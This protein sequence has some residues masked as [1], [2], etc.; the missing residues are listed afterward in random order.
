MTRPPRNVSSLET[1]GAI[2]AGVAKLKSAFSKGAQRFSA[3]GH[4][5]YWQPY[6]GIGA[7]IFQYE[8]VQM[9]WW[10]GFGRTQARFKDNLVVE[11]NP[12]TAG[13]RRDFQ[14]VVAEASGRA[15][16]LHRGRMQLRGKRISCTES[17]AVSQHP[18]AEVTFSDNSQATC[19]VVACLDDEPG[20][21]RNSVAQFV[22]ECQRIRDHYS[23]GAEEADDQAA[24]DMAEVGEDEEGNPERDG[25]YVT[26]PRGAI[27]CERR[28]ARV[29]EVLK[30][31]LDKAGL[32]SSNKRLGRL[33]PD[34]RT[35]GPKPILFELKTSVYASAIQQGLGQLQLYELILGRPHSKVLVLP[36]SMP[37][38]IRQAVDSLSICVLQ[39]RWNGE[40]PVLDRRALKE[41]LALAGHGS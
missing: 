21:I 10:I 24:I 26:P 41:C 11:I 36:H 13:I 31:A 25:T 17:L 19:F 16:L 35:F 7:S 27:T 37:P 4:T 9:R 8:K 20:A 12:P 23:L 2:S 32:R 18:T 28:H 6:L 40:I 38:Q 34:L 29:W 22:R 30:Q 3:H 5:A 14:G 33:G 15:W 39:Y 1:A